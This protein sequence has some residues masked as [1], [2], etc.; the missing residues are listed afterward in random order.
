MFVRLRILLATSGWRSPFNLAYQRLPMPAAWP[1]C[2]YVERQC[3][4]AFMI[5]KEAVHKVVEK[6]NFYAHPIKAAHY[7]VVF[8]NVNGF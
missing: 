1:L 5:W 8:K 2:G 7:L 6:C 3:K 4:F